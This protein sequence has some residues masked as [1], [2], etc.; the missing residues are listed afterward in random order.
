MTSRRSILL[1]LML[2]AFLSVMGL[3]TANAQVPR[4]ISYQGRLIKAGQPV[5]GTVN[6][7]IKIYDASG[8]EKVLLIEI[9]RRRKRA[10][11]STKQYVKDSILY[12]Y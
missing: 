8:A 5:N 11:G 1:S 2:G 12:F 3:Q 6:L 7:T 9:K 10:A 4:S